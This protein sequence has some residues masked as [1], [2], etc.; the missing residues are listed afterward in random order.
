MTVFTAR[1][2]Q[3]KKGARPDGREK[4]RISIQQE[5]HRQV[6]EMKE[7]SRLATMKP[8]IGPSAD[9]GSSWLVV[10]T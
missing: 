1:E 7:C 2:V 9:V 8:Q 6:G 10:P 4:A 3:E 5:P